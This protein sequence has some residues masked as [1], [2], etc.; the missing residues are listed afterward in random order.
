MCSILFLQFQFQQGKICRSL[1]PCTCCMALLGQVVHM[2]AKMNKQGY[3]TLVTLQP[4]K[5][6]SLL[7]VVVNNF[8]L[9]IISSRNF[10]HTR[11]N[12]AS[13]NGIITY[14]A[15][16]AGLLKKARKWIVSPDTILLKLIQCN[17]DFKWHS[18]S[19]GHT[20]TSFLCQLQ[21]C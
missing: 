14:Y 13:L 7:L 4:F 17:R 12:L 9:C 20:K 11:R 1:F 18:K 10:S 21:Q 19:W 2:W 5:Y 15:H 6:F 16:K 3:T 8:V